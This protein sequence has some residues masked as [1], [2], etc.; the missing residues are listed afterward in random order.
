M[1]TFTMDWEDDYESWIE[2]Y[3]CKYQCTNPAHISRVKKG[4]VYR[5]LNQLSTKLWRRMEKWVYRFT[6]SLAVDEWSAS[7]P[8]RFVP[9]KEHI[10]TN[11]TGGLV[12]TRA[13]AGKINNLSNRYRS[14]RRYTRQNWPPLWSSDQSSWLQIQRP[15]FDS[16]NYQKKK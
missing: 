3:G 5:V 12:D 9:G 2:E 13:A 16:R 11:C 4:K 6:G 14:C 1:S 8:G 7:R 10:S 15:G